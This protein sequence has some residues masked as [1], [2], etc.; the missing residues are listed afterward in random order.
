MI[1]E[2]DYLELVQR[3]QVGDSQSLGRLAEV[4]EI[5]IRAYVYRITLNSDMVDDVTQETHLEMVRSLKGLRDPKRF[6]SWIYRVAMSKVSAHFRN[7]RRGHVLTVSALECKDSYYSAR[8]KGEDG[9]GNL[10]RKGDE[11]KVFFGV[12]PFKTESTCHN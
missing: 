10:V 5:R 1:R 2:H 8:C 6:W 9:F 7:Q 4:V 11:G 3:A 12:A